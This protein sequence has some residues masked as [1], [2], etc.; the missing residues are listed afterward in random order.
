MSHLLGCVAPAT[1][2]PPPT[3]H[4]GVDRRVRLSTDGEGPLRLVCFRASPCLLHVTRQ[5]YSGD[6]VAVAAAAAADLTAAHPVGLAV[7]EGSA[8]FSAAA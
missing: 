2:L 3:L 4:D 7:V 1:L 6:A 5:L 8:G